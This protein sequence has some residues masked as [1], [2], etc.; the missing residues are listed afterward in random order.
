MKVGTVGLG[1][2]ADILR[3]EAAERIT[4]LLYS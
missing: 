3:L 4:T 2:I 1:T